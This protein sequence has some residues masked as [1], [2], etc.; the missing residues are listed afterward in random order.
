MDFDFDDL[1]DSGNDKDFDSLNKYS[2]I[3]KQLQDH[4]E[5]EQKGYKVKVNTVK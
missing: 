4:D 5:E 3:E 1:A 2:K